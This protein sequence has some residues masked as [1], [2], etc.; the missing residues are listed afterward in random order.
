MR[1]RAAELWLTAGCLLITGCLSVRSDVR[2]TPKKKSADTHAKKK[3]TDD[4]AKTKE[5]D[6]KRERLSSS[7]AVAELKQQRTQMQATRATE[8]KATAL[9]ASR[10]ALVLA[11]KALRLHDDRTAPQRIARSEQ[12]LLRSQ[13]RISESEEELQQ[14][15]MMYA[16]EEFAD[17]T[18]EIVLERS[19]RRLARSRRDREL[20]QADS[21]V[22]TEKTL[23]RD[24][25]ALAHAVKDKQRAV[26]KAE[27]DIEVTRLSQEIDALNTAAELTKLRNEIEDLD[28]SE[29]E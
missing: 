23:P 8:D 15:E 7:L 28:D 5:T 16:E 10:R 27:H 1:R 20:Q 21:T 2:A 13:D 3:D 17:Q 11:E 9:V 4:A 29:Q 24:R 6:R 25:E 22:L 18:K 14:L 12:S 19:R 26:A